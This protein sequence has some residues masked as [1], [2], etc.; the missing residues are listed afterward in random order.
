MRAYDVLIGPCSDRA[1]CP[2]PSFRRNKLKSP[3]LK[4]GKRGRG[5]KCNFADKCVFK[6][7]LGTSLHELRSPRRMKIGSRCDGDAAEGLWSA[8][9]E[10]SG[11]TALGCAGGARAASSAPRFYTNPYPRRSAPCQSGV[12]ATLCRHSK[13]TAAPIH[14]RR[15][16]GAAHAYYTHRY[17]RSRRINHWRRLLH[18]AGFSASLRHVSRAWPDRKNREATFGSDAQG[19]DRE[20][21][22]DCVGKSVGR[23]E[24]DRPPR[25]DGAGT[26]GR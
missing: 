21:R 20:A 22:E 9:A 15:P 17:F 1:S 26:C 25:A 11:D 10:R 12:A 5:A 3:S 4:K 6:C 7:N 23:F 14:L 24:A 16:P 19:I 18:S 8:V 13:T 2:N